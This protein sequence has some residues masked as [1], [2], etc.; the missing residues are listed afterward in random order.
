MRDIFC[1]IALFPCSSLTLQLILSSPAFLLH[2]TA[3]TQVSFPGNRFVVSIVATSLT[4][5]AK[6]KL[7]DLEM[8]VGL[9]SGPVT[10]GVL[11]GEKSRFQLFGDTVNMASRMGK[12]CNQSDWTGLRLVLCPMHLPH[13]RM[14]PKIC[15]EC[16]RQSRPEKGIGFKFLSPRLIC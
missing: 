10:A 7:G 15:F 9:H 4:C 6:K 14:L 5:C 2:F 16:E 3:R 1:I 12:Y 13:M 8:R 11:Q